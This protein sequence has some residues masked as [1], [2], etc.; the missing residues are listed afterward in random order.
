[1]PDGRSESLPNETRPRPT[2]VTGTAAHRVPRLPTPS[3]ASPHPR[4][5]GAAAAPLGKWIPTRPPR[6]TGAHGVGE[7]R[8]L[9]PQ[10]TPVLLPG[11]SCGRRSLVG[12][13]PWGPKESDTTERLHSLNAHTHT[14]TRTHARP[15]APGQGLV[16]GD[17]P[18]IFSGS[19]KSSW[20]AGPAAWCQGDT[21][22]SVLKRRDGP[23]LPPGP[24]CVLSYFSRVQTCV[25]PWT[26]ARQ[27]PL[28]IGFSRQAL[29][30]VTISSSRGSSQPR[31]RT[32]VS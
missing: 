25:T 5:G 16:E 3:S 19:A 8:E 12:R 22:W 31:D 26:I 32:R 20:T 30:W 21:C 27:A 4:C 24:A 7:A 9:P 6:V 17:C 2:R 11:K 14:D 1:M 23:E 10:P 13:S 28:S 15:P 18:P 29:E